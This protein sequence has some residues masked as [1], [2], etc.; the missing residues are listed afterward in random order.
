MTDDE[1]LQRLI[2]AAKQDQVLVK[3]QLE[4]LEALGTSEGHASTQQQVPGL[5]PEET[6]TA[7][8]LC[9]PLDR[10]TEDRFVAAI[11]RERSRDAV[12]TQSTVD[13][14]SDSQQGTILR[15]SRRW[16]PPATAVLSVLAAAAGLA[17]WL[18]AG[19]S[20]ATLPSYKVVVA[21][22][23]QAFRGAD[24]EIPSETRL[25]NG[26]V[27]DISI[28]PTQDVH[29]LLDVRTYAVQNGS[30]RALKLP[31]EISP[32][33]SVRFYGDVNESFGFPVG[34]FKMVAVLGFKDTIPADI[35]T[36]LAATSNNVDPVGRGWA[37][38]SVGIEYT[39]S[40]K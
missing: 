16:M 2:S 29:R 17:L 18:R 36:R 6:A 7:R 39:A 33:G 22:G 37:S 10:A 21:S 14:R 20:E 35:Q 8:A 3:S 24:E 19:P 15:M 40:R 32:T 34:R 9:R 26:A 13:T 23:E 12:P 28:V 31:T 1:I 25:S 5:S 27:L 11:E 4:H 38:F 30:S